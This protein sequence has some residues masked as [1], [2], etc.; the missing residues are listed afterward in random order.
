MHASWT[1]LKISCSKYEFEYNL[2]YINSSLCHRKKHIRPRKLENIYKSLLSSKEMYSRVNCEEK[3]I[4][5]NEL[6]MKKYSLLYEQESLD[7]IKQFIEYLRYTMF[8]RFSD[9]WLHSIDVI[10]NNYDE[11]LALLES[12][13]FGEFERLGKIGIVGTIYGE[14]WPKRKTRLVFP[15]R[16]Y[17]VT[18]WCVADTEL[19]TLTIESIS[20]NT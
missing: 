18:A 20:I 5:L 1:Y 9:T 12:S 17:T 8:Q 6:S 11:D 3:C 2:T 19:E 13:L 15:I 14:D 10:L 4:H 16:S 7:K